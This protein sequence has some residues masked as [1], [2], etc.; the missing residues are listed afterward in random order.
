MSTSLGLYQSIK[1]HQALSPQMQHSLTILQA[2][3]VELS[4][5]IQQ[6]L[7]SN[8]LL[9]MSEDK[10]LG[11]QS[12]EG[13]LQE[14]EKWYD[15]LGPNFEGSQRSTED[16]KKRQFFF[17]SQVV[18]ESMVTELSKQLSL[19]CTDNTLLEAAHYIIG[20]LDDRGY[21]NT[22]L[23]NIAHE[24]G[25]PYGLVEKALELVQSLDPPGIAA[26]NLS[27]CLLLQLKALGKENSLEF[28]IVSEYLTLLE[29]KKLSEIAKQLK[30]NLK[31]VQEAVESIR[32]LNPFPGSKYRGD[33]KEK[34][35][36][37]DL[38]VVKEA[39]SWKVYFNEEVIPR[40]RINH[41]YESLLSQ[42]DKDPY[43]KNYLKEKKRSG[44][45]LIKCLK[46]RESTLL[47][48]AEA[49]IQ[50]QEDFFNFGPHSL[51]PLTMSEIAKK[52]DVHE[53]TVSRAIANKYI[54]T[55]HGIFEL[56]Y[57]F[58]SGFQKETGEF[59]ANQI[60]KEAIER[61]IRNEDPKSPLSDQQI[62][63]LLAKEG[64]KMARRT[65]AKYRAHLKILPSHLRRTS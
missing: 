14:K 58:N 25:L 6:E 31:Q 3:A 32:S 64:I 21:L 55:P 12:I 51:K 56:K 9:E 47:R 50:S 61:L 59:V 28:R 29:K 27:E 26:R 41:Y 57:F 39:G 33:E 42:Q 36:Q 62:V 5:I 17:D 44:L 37:V 15:Y 7:L 4:A 46:M 8:P 30:V 34:I 52:I 22:E 48:V 23:E 45:F 63:A 43:L 40:L 53:T 13:L 38:I 2:P 19:V 60:V 10:P 49:I 16:E 24:L 65:I 1:L 11:G 18:P 35:I 20:N 54:K